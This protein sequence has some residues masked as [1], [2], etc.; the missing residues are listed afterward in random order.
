[1]STEDVSLAAIQ[2]MLNR[3]I[4]EDIDNTVRSEV[5]LRPDLVGLQ[6]FDEPLVGCADPDDPLF[7]YLKSD[8]QTYGDFFRMPREWLPDANSVISI[9]FPFT[10]TVRESNKIDPNYPS[11]EWLHGR[12]EGQAFIQ[13]TL[14]ALESH[15]TERGYNAVIPTMSEAFAVRRQPERYDEGC[16]PILSNWSERHVAYVAGLGT[17]GLS[18]HLITE[19]GVSGR[20]GSIVTNA[21][22]APT[23]RGYTEPFERC[24]L[25]GVCAAQC[26]VDAIRKP[27]KGATPVEI[28]HS[29]DNRI[30]S[31]YVDRMKEKFAPRYGCG[32]CQLKVPCEKGIPQARI[33]R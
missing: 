32:K 5:A 9:F 18:K 28:A 25:C 26:P 14:K 3:C 33:S 30:C 13:K 16:P 10:E 1:M 4:H 15:F 27:E 8:E 22:I 7:T 23:S 2:K 11:P 29:K 19:K 12:I 6:L 21:K 24:T 31:M 17:F 20:F